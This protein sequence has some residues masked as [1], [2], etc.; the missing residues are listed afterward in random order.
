MLLLNRST[1][2]A[3][4][5]KGENLLSH[6]ERPGQ[7]ISNG[8][9]SAVNESNYIDANDLPFTEDELFRAFAL[10]GDEQEARDVAHELA[11]LLSGGTYDGGWSIADEAFSALALL[12]DDLGERVDTLMRA[13]WKGMRPS[14]VHAALRREG[15]PPGSA[16]TPSALRA[17]DEE[18]AGYVA[19]WRAGCAALAEWVRRRQAGETVEDEPPS[20][21][22]FDQ[23]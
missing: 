11:E 23:G 12:S 18:I 8:R 6:G 21:S 1:M 10:T 15:L 4:D 2:D 16:P 17:A 5:A 22:G 3:Y 20:W 9:A 13:R 14:L 19:Q 7:P